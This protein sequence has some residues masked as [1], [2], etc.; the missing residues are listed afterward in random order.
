MKCVVFRIG[1]LRIADFYMIKQFIPE[2]RLQLRKT[3]E[4]RTEEDRFAEIENEFEEITL[5]DINTVN[6]N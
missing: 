6:N 1:C 5:D 4:E 3:E 2:E